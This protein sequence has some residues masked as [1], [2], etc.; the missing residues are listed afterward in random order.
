MNGVAAARFTSAP[1][2]LTAGRVVESTSFK[3]A[4]AEFQF[5]DAS[6]GA[7]EYPLLHL[8]V[9]ACDQ[10]ESIEERRQKRVGVLFDIPSGRFRQDFGKSCSDFVEEAG[11]GHG[12]KTSEEA[13]QTNSRSLESS[14]AQV[15]AGRSYP[16]NPHHRETTV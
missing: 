13:I 2:G 12:V 16:S 7:L 9:V 6:L 11:V 3:L 15:G 10:I 8:E 5:C 1:K 14:T 4:D